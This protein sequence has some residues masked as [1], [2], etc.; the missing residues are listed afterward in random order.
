[1]EQLEWKFHEERVQ[2]HPST[3]A[4]RELRC[5]WP[6]VRVEYRTSRG[7]SCKPLKGNMDM[8]KRPLGKNMFL[9]FFFAYH[10]S[11]LSSI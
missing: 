11:S 10:Q 5:F 7:G 4:S 8:E 9:P 2:V 1:M 6:L 3:H